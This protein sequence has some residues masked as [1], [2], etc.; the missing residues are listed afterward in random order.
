MVAEASE[1]RD[2]AISFSE[3]VAFM[4]DKIV[5]KKDCEGFMKRVFDYFDTEGN[6]LIGAKELK[7]MMNENGENLTDQEVEKMLE[8]GAFIN[9]GKLNFI[10]F[11]RP[12]VFPGDQK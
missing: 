11:I 3:M 7:E 6:E 12:M 4:A 8:E 1:F 2:G 10:D 5:Q 9:E